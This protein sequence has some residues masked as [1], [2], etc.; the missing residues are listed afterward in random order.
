MTNFMIFKAGF[1]LGKTMHPLSDPQRWIKE[2]V[3]I[4]FFY[5]CFAGGDLFERVSK[6]EYRLTEAKCQIFMR[7][8]L[9]QDRPRHTT[10]QYPQGCGSGSAFIFPPGSGSVFNMRIRI[11]I[12]EEKM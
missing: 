11:L 3:L 9:R 2:R 10:M 4:I 7:Q 5:R 12:H 8:I 6:S 1:C